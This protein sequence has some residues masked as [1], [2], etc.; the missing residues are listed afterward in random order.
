MSGLP[1]EQLLS[2]L[3]RCVAKVEVRMVQIL[4]TGKV[5]GATQQ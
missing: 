3:C 5:Y 4:E 2:L 1:C